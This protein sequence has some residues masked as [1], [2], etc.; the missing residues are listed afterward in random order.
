MEIPA[1]AYIGE[2]SQATFYT[3][4]N[5][6]KVLRVFGDV[7]MGFARKLADALDA[8]PGVKHVAL[9][10]GGGLVKEAIEAA[11]LIRSRKLTTV[12]WNECYS[13][14]TMVFLGGVDREIW[15]PYPNLSFHQV[16]AEG[17]ALPSSHPIYKTI[18]EFAYSMGADGDAFV[19]LI[20]SSLP[21]KLTDADLFD[22]CAAYIATWV[23][24]AC[25]GGDRF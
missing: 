23:Q 12:L 19:K 11:I 10:S 3:V 17:K 22:L 13:A 15:S 16:S 25:S 4:E 14:C 9:G 5:D 1:T 18:R 7:E 20:L 8:N 21:D 2:R 24:R 6:G